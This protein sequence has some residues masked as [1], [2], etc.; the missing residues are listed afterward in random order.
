M[1]LSAAAQAALDK[2]ATRAANLASR[3]AGLG[4]FDP[5]SVE[6]KPLSEKKLKALED[7]KE[8]SRPIIYKCY[9]LLQTVESLTKPNFEHSK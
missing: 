6:T 7:A 1:P 3:D 4:E 9:F 5:P 8:R 2:A